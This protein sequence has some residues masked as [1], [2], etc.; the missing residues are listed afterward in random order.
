MVFC[1]WL[2]SRNIM[3]SQFI[4]VVAC[5]NTS[6]LIMAK[7]Y[8]IMWIDHLWLIH[9][10]TDGHLGC[11][12]LLVIVNSAAMNICVYKFL[13][14]DLFSALLGIYLGV[15]WLGLNSMSHFLRNRQT[16]FHSCIVL[17]SHEQRMMVPISPHPCQL[18]VLFFSFFFLTS[19]LEYNS[20]TMLC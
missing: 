3:F 14:K 17:Y 4:P 11:F 2:L 8:S 5:I 7:Y 15:K 9:L 16:V 18:H 6:F 13:F 1:H 10:S 12:H 19:L 20:F